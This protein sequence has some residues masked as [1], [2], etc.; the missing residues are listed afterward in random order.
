MEKEKKKV[1]PLV[2]VNS[3]S[4]RRLDRCSFALFFFFLCRHFF[5]WGLWLPAS[6]RRV[7]HVKLH[8]FGLGLPLFPQLTLSQWILNT[9]VVFL[10]LLLLPWRTEKK[11]K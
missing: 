1:E 2:D 5:F 9:S 10:L 11:K 7:T 8:H 3:L 6:V 4:L